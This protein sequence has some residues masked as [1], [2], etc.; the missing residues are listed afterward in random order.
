M[1]KRLFNKIIL[2]S[3]LTFMLIIAPGEINA[4]NQST[5]RAICTGLAIDTSEKYPDGVS[6]TSQ[7]AIPQAGGQYKQNISLVTTEGRDLMDAFNQMDYQIG[8]KVR[9][10]HCCY[11]VIG[12]EASQRNITTTLDYLV[13]GNNTGNNIVLVHTTGLAKDLISLA[14]SVNTNEVDNLQTI[15]R[16]NDQYLFSQ[17]ANLKSFYNDY[18]SPHSTSVINCINKITEQDSTSGSSGGGGG[19]SGGSSGGAGGNAQSSEGSGES[20]STSQD[21]IKNNG[22]VSVFK[23]GKLATVLSSEQSK[24][25]NWL[26]SGLR[27]SYVVLEHINTDIF[28]DATIGFTLMDKEVKTDFRFVN[29]KPCVYATLNL[30]LRT[31]MILQADGTVL[32]DKNYRDSAIQHAFNEKANQDVRDAMQ[33]QQEYGFD[34]YDFYHDFEIANYHEW[35]KY[36][37]SLPDKENYIK[38]IEVFVKVNTDVYGLSSIIKTFR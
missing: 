34:V 19:S 4:P 13:R 33:L 21:K 18:L 31:E 9:L 6:V 5:I 37:N 24:K 38:D 22:E 25:F 17:E 12:Y 29:G 16:Y 11:I 3:V 23:K 8:K 14:T 27:E 2:F 20:Q 15:T 26:D 1:T 7:I 32:P 10:A 35:Q 36:L 28:D 30:K